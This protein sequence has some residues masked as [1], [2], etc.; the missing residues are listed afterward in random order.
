MKT[1]RGTRRT[2]EIERIRRRGAQQELRDIDEPKKTSRPAE[3]LT[4]IH[5]A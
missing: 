4:E 1:D 5:N 2:S 3:N